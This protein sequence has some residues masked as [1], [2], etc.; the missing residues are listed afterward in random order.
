MLLYILGNLGDFSWQ[1]SQIAKYEST[2]DLVRVNGT[3]VNVITRH[4]I[5]LWLR[6]EETTPWE[7]SDSWHG[8]WEKH[9]GHQQDD[10][11]QSGVVSGHTTYW[12]KSPA[13]FRAKCV[14]EVWGKGLESFR[15]QN[16]K[17]WLKVT[18]W[19]VSTSITSELPIA[20]QAVFAIKVFLFVRQIWKTYNREFL[21]QLHEHRWHI[22]MKLL[23]TVKSAALI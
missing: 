16:T 14:L 23:V 10:T 2:T 7:M 9:T 13:H 19:M 3:A 18:T 12:R 11:Q 6:W 21:K 4:W 8:S 22:V 17:R 20:A 15:T 1:V 5:V